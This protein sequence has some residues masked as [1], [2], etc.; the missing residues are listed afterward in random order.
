LL[1]YL[2]DAILNRNIADVGYYVGGMKEAELKISETKK[3]IIATYSMAS[4]G[5]DI[6]S[7]TT[8][9][10]ATPKTDIVQAVGRILRTKHEQPVVI[11]ILDEH[12]IFK[13]QFAQRKRFYVKQKY[14]IIETSNNFND[15][16]NKNWKVNHDP[17]NKIVKKVKDKCLI[18]L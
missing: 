1:K 17:N 3:V 16:D 4:E 18:E 11:D 15:F 13:K 14:K 12:E 8:L 2:H 5:L 7:L 9:L 10:L 6:K